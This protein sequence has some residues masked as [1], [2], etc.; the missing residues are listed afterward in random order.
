MSE[1]AEIGH[2][3]VARFDGNRRGEGPA[4]HDVIGHQPLAAPGEVRRKPGDRVGGIAHH[5][6]SVT[7]NPDIADRQ[8]DLDTPKIGRDRHTLSDHGPR[9]VGVVGDQ[10]RDGG[11]SALPAAVDDLEGQ[12]DLGSCPPHVGGGG[13]AIEILAEDERELDLQLGFDQPRKA[14]RFTGPITDVAD[15]YP[16]IGSIAEKLSC[17]DVEVRPI[18]YPAIRSPAATAKCCLWS[19]T[20]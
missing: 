14:H 10:H 3:D 18:L 16:L 6:F 19:C 20:A 1:L 17:A 15:K 5:I 8:V 7:L 13:T 12:R 4:Q 2:R 9:R 11:H